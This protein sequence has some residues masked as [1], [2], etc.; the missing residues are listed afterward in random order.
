MSTGSA[1]TRKL[2]KTVPVGAP[3]PIVPRQNPSRKIK[4]L[5]IDPTEVARQL[6]LMES[7]LFCKIRGTECLARAEGGQ[8]ENDNIK[9]VISMSNKVRT[10]LS[11][12]L[13]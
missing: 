6:T 13:L 9:A 12:L 2:S 11:F 4:F 3:S 5:D 7:E 8:M 1:P 10:L